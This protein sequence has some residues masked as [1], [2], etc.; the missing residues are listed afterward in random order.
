MQFNLCANVKSENLLRNEAEKV[1]PCEDVRLVAPLRSSEPHSYAPVRRETW[2]PVPISVGGEAE[3]RATSQRTAHCLKQT[4]P[5]GKRE[6]WATGKDPE[7]W[8]YKLEC[9]D[10]GAHRIA[11]E[12]E[13]PLRSRA[14]TSPDRK[15]TRLNSSHT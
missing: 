14:P 9:C 3:V 13:S 5:R 12:T 15:S 6:G 2:G 7:E 4:A 10:I 1:G 8:Q 11:G